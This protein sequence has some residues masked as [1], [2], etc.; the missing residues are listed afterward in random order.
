MVSIFL[1]RYKFIF[2]LE[3]LYFFYGKENKCFGFLWSETYNASS[4]KSYHCSCSC[5]YTK[6]HWFNWCHVEVRY[7][8]SFWYMFAK[9]P[10]TCLSYCIRSY[11]GATFRRLW[12]LITVQSNLSSTLKWQCKT[13]CS[14]CPWAGKNWSGHLKFKLRFVAGY[15]SFIWWFCF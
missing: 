10:T 12:F 9:V 8:F 2:H 1:F 14:C 11:H 15:Y 5:V 3:N 4:L 7:I 6:Q 13:E